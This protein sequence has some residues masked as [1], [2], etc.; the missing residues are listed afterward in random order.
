L[1]ESHNHNITNDKEDNCDV[2]SRVTDY[3]E[4]I[5]F[6]LIFGFLKNSDIYFLIV[7]QRLLKIIKNY[8]LNPL[9]LL[10]I[11]KLIFILLLRNMKIHSHNGHKQI[12]TE[13]TSNNNKHNKEHTDIT[14]IIHDWACVI[15]APVNG[16]V[17]VVGPPFEG[18]QHEQTDHRVQDVVEIDV[19]VQPHA[20]VFGETVGAVYVVERG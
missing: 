6:Y 19:P 4:Q 10:L 8:N 13:N 18:A 14:I 3:L 15:L 1:I 5:G 2:E 16:G 7:K 9:F 17:H 20:R 12:N 11:K